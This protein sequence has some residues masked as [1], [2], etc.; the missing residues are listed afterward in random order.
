MDTSPIPNAGAPRKTGSVERFCRSS[1]GGRQRRGHFDFKRVCRRLPVP[2]ICTGIGG[3]EGDFPGTGGRPLERRVLRKPGA[4]RQ[5]NFCRETYDRSTRRDPSVLP[6]MADKSGSS[7]SP[8][9]DSH[10]RLR[11]VPGRNLSS[12]ARRNDA[13]LLSSSANRRNG[14]LFAS[15]SPGSH[16]GCQFCRSQELGRAA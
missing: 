2:A 6:E 10:H 11:R 5:F 8:G 13:R 14:N 1:S 9:H 16:G 7:S 12:Q 4:S 3:M 15:R